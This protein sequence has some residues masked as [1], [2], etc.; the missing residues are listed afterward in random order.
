M[1]KEG[2]DI[3]CTGSISKTGRF[4]KRSTRNLSKRGKTALANS[5]EAIFA[6]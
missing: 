4:S 2:A 3:M 1:R 6:K 5:D